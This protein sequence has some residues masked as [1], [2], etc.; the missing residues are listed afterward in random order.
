MLK[1]KFKNL[2]LSLEGDEMDLETESKIEAHPEPEGSPFEQSNYSPDA[3][4]SAEEEIAA[5]EIM[6]KLTEVTKDIE[7][8]RTRIDQL[9]TT[10]QSLEEMVEVLVDRVDT[11]EATLT[12]AEL[13]DLNT[14]VANIVPSEVIEKPTQLIA[15]TEAF[16]Y[17]PRVALE[18]TT[19]S[20]IEA[21]KR[22]WD[23]IVK[24]VKRITAG[25]RKFWDWVKK[26]LGM[27]IK[28]AEAHQD[29]I[30]DIVHNTVDLAAVTKLVQAE[31][32]I[33]RD[34]YQRNIWITKERRVAPDIAH[35]L[36][37]LKNTYLAVQSVS[38]EA[39]EK[40]A[41]DLVKGLSAIAGKLSHAADVNEATADLEVY[42]RQT[43]SVIAGHE[44]AVRSVATTHLGSY[45]GCIE[46]VASVAPFTFSK[47]QLPSQY[48]GK[49]FDLTE[50]RNVN[51]ANLEMQIAYN[52]LIETFNGT[53]TRIE[54]AISQL[55]HL[56]DSHSGV[57][58]KD[59]AFQSEFKRS[60]EKFV[61]MFNNVQARSHSLGVRL[62]GITTTVDVI[63]ANTIRAY[64]KHNHE[65]D[66]KH[67][68]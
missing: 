26:L 1:S 18:T 17:S 30:T 28:K 46:V 61:G 36:T 33:L 52:N 68:A 43:G 58:P 14:T 8:D 20:L 38:Y 64:Q 67:H 15:S 16:G 41:D 24:L 22:V 62:V 53:A 11:H 63:V 47:P 4:L 56:I 6:V 29:A 7:G 48:K 66:L 34:S 31:P 51:T 42:K 32:M 25:L 40:W 50:L 3:E 5:G 44:A 37:K 27:G 10:A 49:M 13:V 35:A 39:T 65:P 9:V 19:E 2:V 45:I 23:H 12:E 55:D 57:T 21:L 60:V 59:K 54:H